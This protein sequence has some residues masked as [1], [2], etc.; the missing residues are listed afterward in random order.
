MAE[1]GVP[2]G[3]TRSLATELAV[4]TVLGAAR[5]MEA[6]GEHP[7]VPRERVSSPGGTTVAAIRK[8]D[9]RGVRAAFIVTAEAARNRS[10]Q[11]SEEASN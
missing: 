9:V 7:V 6:T 10:H 8:L 11:L 2:L 3:L 4:G 5:L 1:A